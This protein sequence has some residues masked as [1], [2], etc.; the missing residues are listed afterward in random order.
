MLKEKTVQELGKDFEKYIAGEL[1]AEGLGKAS[2]EVGSGSGKK[3]GDIAA[4][5]PFLL[6][7]KNQKTIKIQEWVRQ[8]KEQARIGNYD[9]DK[10]AVVYRDPQSPTDRPEAYVVIDFYQFTELLK[11]DAEPRVKAPDR[12]L[13]YDLQNLKSLAQR[14]MKQL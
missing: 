10:W 12:Q 8:A 2:P 7:V 13:K 11:K 5:L 1:E 3:K 9:Q 6:E 4:N 14:V